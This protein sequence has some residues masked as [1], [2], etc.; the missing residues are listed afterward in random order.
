MERIGVASGHLPDIYPFSHSTSIGPT[1]DDVLFESSSVGSKD[2]DDTAAKGADY[3]DGRP[4]ISNRQLLDAMADVT[5][6]RSLYLS[7]TKK[8]IM[9]YEACGKIN[10]VIRLKADLAGLAL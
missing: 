4:S 6:F 8:A 9:A 3:N 1:T 5:R 2:E 10:S 7:L